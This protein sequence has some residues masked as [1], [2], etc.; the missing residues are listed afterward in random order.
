MRLDRLL[1]RTQQIVSIQHMCVSRAHI[2]R[3]LFEAYLLVCV[4]VL[5]PESGQQRTAFGNGNELVHD[6][7]CHLNLVA[8]VKKAF[9]GTTVFS[10]EHTNM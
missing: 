6:F 10:L 2:V 3:R 1:E 8:T 7:Q 5:W 4:C 9:G